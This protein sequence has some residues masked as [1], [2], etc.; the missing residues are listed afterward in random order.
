MA[1]RKVW[2]GSVGPY[3]YDDADLI[4]D[5]D[6]DLTGE[7]FAGVSTTGQ[8]HVSQDATL[9]DHV[10]RF[11]QVQN[12]ILNSHL[13][14]SDTMLA[15]GTAN[16]VTASELR[17]FLNGLTTA[18]SVTVTSNGLDPQISVTA[19]GLKF[20]RGTILYIPEITGVSNSTSFSINIPVGWRSA[21]GVG[22]PTRVVNGATDILGMIVVRSAATFPIYNN[23]DIAIPTGWTSTGTK[24][25]R[26]CILTYVI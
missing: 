17:A 11:S 7:T 9:P 15:S 16:Q 23:Y 5:V 6:G 12:S 2:L 26:A 20:G 22:I 18:T 4:N 1:V 13:Q 14:N 3:Q 10:A 21:V 19:L 24:S 25:L 8:M